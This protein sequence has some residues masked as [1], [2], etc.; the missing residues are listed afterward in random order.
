MQ[1]VKRGVIKS[2]ILILIFISLLLMFFYSGY[3]IISYLIDN[4][5]N[6]N[7][8]ETIMKKAIV[9]KEASNEENN[10]FVIDFDSLKEVNNDTVAYVKVGGTNIDYVV[11]RGDDNQYYLNHNFNKEYNVSGWIYAD[12]KNR[13]DEKDYNIILFGHN[14]LD[15]SMFGTLKNVLT[16]D[17]HRQFNQNKIVLVTEMNTYYYQVFSTYEI[18]PEDYYIKTDFSN[19][20]EYSEFISVLKSRSNFNYQ[21]EVSSEDKILTLSSCSANGS[22]RVVLHAKLLKD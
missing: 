13:F 8:Q 12:Y 7:I 6:K 17:Y 20:Q 14:T 21:V 22:K 2:V 11:V 5:N 18:I 4:Y 10:E 3:R 1:K 19:E 9:I 15:G 16:D